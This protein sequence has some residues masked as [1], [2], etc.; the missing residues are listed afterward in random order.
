MLKNGGGAIVNN[1]GNFKRNGSP[2]CSIYRAT[3]SAVANISQVAALEYA[4]NN[5]R[6]DA[7][8]SDLL[9]NQLTSENGQSSTNA[10][11]IPMNCGDSPQEIAQTVVW[12]CC[13]Q[14]SYITGH[15]VDGG[16]AAL[17]IS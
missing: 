9:A 10:A 15:T 7:I 5:I 12:L 11:F 1:I 13:D 4:R 2:G 14:A 16:L 8:A 17:A 3:K 6:L